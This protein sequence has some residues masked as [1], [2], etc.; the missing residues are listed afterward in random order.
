MVYEDLDQKLVNTLLAN[1]RAS[2]RSLGEEMDVSVTTVSNHLSD[3]E[4]AGV[5]EAYTPIVDYDFFGYDVTAILKFKVE[6]SALGTIT[7]RLR[8]HDKM[9]SVYEVTGHHDIVAVGKFLDT[10]DMNDELKELLDEPDIQGSNTS[11]PSTRPVRTS[12]S[13]STLSEPQSNVFLDR[14]HSAMTAPSLS[15][16]S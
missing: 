6:G 1:G 11:V 16:C 5:I 9:V 4:N 15:I 7:D 13:N 2:L 3:L 14:F 8:T 12:S 10:G